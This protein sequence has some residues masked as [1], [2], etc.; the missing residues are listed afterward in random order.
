MVQPPG[1]FR[2]NHRVSYLTK[3]KLNLARPPCKNFNDW[4]I[5]MYGKNSGM[6]KVS[7][8]VQGFI[9]HL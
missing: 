3:I 7:V 8:I 1:A 9:F 2:R 4:A 6:F 5:L